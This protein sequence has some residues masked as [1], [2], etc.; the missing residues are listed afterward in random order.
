M[1]IWMINYMD[2]NW[3]FPRERENL[4][5][6]NSNRDTIVLKSGKIIHARMMDYRKKT[7]NYVFSDKTSLH[8]SKIQRIYVRRFS[9]NMKRSASKKKAIKRILRK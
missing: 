3:D 9:A 8:W 1:D 6:I 2:T 5:P 7:G 4:A